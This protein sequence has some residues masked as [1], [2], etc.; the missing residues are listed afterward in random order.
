MKILSMH[1]FGVLSCTYWCDILCLSYITDPMGQ[2]PWNLFALVKEM[3]GYL[4]EFRCTLFFIEHQQGLT[5]SCS[6]W[7]NYLCSYKRREFSQKW[8]QHPVSPNTDYEPAWQGTVATSRLSFPE[9]YYGYDDKL[10]PWF[11]TREW[12]EKL[13][14]SMQFKWSGQLYMAHSGW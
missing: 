10:M 4:P 9:N 11:T 14:R 1:C 7:D 2:S 13:K 5:T 8:F 3:C 12:A 6:I